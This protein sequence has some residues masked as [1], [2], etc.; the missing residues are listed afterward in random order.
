MAAATLGHSQ[1]FKV[2]D[3]VVYT[4]CGIGRIA[5]LVTKA[6]Q[7]KP[8]CEYYEVIVD[9]STIWVA[10]DAGPASGLRL[11][12]LKAELARYRDILRGRPGKL[13][14]DARQ[15]KLE[16]ADRLKSG[17]FQATCEVVRDL[18]ALSWSKALNEADSI[19]LRKMRDGL[20]QEWA[21][22]ADMPLADAVEEVNGLLLESRQ[23]YAA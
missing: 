10:V 5:A 21:A 3:A 6:F 11:L 4:A 17:S 9:R 18:T 1:P 16:V 13:I 23:A 2:N 14:A 8:A 7:D 19:T 12:T 22:A 15:R 20:Y